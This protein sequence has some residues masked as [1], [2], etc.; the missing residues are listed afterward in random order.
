MTAL[1]H[2]LANLLDGTLR[3]LELARRQAHASAETSPSERAVPGQV[4]GSVL[5]RGDIGRR[6]DVV[7]TGMSHMVSLLREMSGFSS[8]ARSLLA[9]PDPIPTSDTDDEHPAGRGLSRGVPTLAEAVNHAA[10]VLEPVA[11]D[12]NIRIH[13]D[14]PTSFQRLAA[15][16]L[17]GVVA[18]AIRNA[19]ESIEQARLSDGP[20]PGSADAASGPISAGGAIQINGGMTDDQAGVW[21]EIA[22]DGIGFPAASG[23]DPA[24]CFEIGY[25]T[26]PGSSGIGLAVA[27]D[28][29]RRLGGTIALGPRDPGTPGR[30]GAVLRV[31]W[32]IIPVTHPHLREGS[33]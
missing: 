5:P 22:D 13:V 1:V 32:P 9:E 6:L 31:E 33:R 4:P 30:R 21:I 18:G 14:L 25:T 16:G 2:E 3:T 26:K 23:L 10:E 28:T 7:H 19:I 29:V 17:F 11:A 15:R 12:L 27:R 24:R 8:D 20:A